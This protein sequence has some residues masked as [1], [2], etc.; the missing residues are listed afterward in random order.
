MSDSLFLTDCREKLEVKMI[1][2]KVKQ[3]V[4]VSTH[5]N[6][7]RITLYAYSVRAFRIIRQIGT[8]QMIY[9]KMEKILLRRENIIAGTVLLRTLFRQRGH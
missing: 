7:V 5:M 4:I 8:P 1:I 6:K 9:T 2:F 3:T